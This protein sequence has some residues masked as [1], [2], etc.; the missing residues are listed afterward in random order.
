M[1]A[2][3]QLTGGG[4]ATI[5]VAVWGRLKRAE[6]WEQLPGAA[7]ANLDAL[8][9]DSWTPV[10]DNVAMYDMVALYTTGSAA[11]FTYDGDVT[12]Q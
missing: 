7:I 11:A 5:P 4:G 3:R 10:F 9:D 6:T 2:I 8:T 1:F 12:F